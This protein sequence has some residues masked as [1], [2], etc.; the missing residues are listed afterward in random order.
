MGRL[1][2]LLKRLS[3]TRRENRYIKEAVALAQQLFVTL[4]ITFLLLILAETIWE[5]SVSFY[6]NLNYLLTAVIAVGVIALLAKPQRAQGVQRA[7]A[8]HLRRRHITMAACAGLAG[9]AIVWYKTQEIGWPSY[10]ISAVSGA[11]IVL[12][13][14]LMRRADDEEENEGQNS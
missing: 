7:E 2:I 5:G 11:L 13:F 14:M 9:A 12:L 10:I 8:K 1:G 4:F 6:L 3:K